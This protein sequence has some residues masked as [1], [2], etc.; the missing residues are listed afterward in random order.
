MYRVKYYTG[1]WVKC[2]RRLAPHKPHQNPN[3]LTNSSQIV[4]GPVSFCVSLIVHVRRWYE[5]S[6]RTVKARLV[7]EVYVLLDTLA[8]SRGDLGPSSS[9][10]ISKSKRERSKSR[11]RKLRDSDPFDSGGSDGESDDDKYDRYVCAHQ[12]LLLN[13]TG[14]PVPITARVHSTPLRPFHHIPSNAVICP[15]I[16]FKAT[17]GG[18]RAAG[19]GFKATG[20]GFKATWGGF[21]A[22]RVNSRPQGMDSGPRGAD[23]KLPG[24]G[25]YTC[26]AAACSTYGDGCVRKREL[27]PGAAVC[28]EW[29]GG[30]G[31]G[32]SQTAPDPP[33]G[34]HGA[35]TTLPTRPR[36]GHRNID[37]EDPNEPPYHSGI[38]FSRQC[39]AGVICLCQA[40]RR[41]LPCPRFSLLSLRLRARRAR[42]GCVVG[43]DAGGPQAPHRTRGTKTSRPARWLP[44]RRQDLYFPG[45]A[46]SVERAPHG[47]ATLGA[48]RGEE[49]L[50]VGLNAGMRRLQKI[51]RRA[52]FP[53]GGVA[54]QG[55]TVRVEPYR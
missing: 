28:Q 18:F 13:F 15:G 33:Q 2:F 55:L 47:L 5:H 23:P 10:V 32:V 12:I 44:R 19:G 30:E 39:F 20:G 52:E 27:R 42:R 43:A 37:R 51:G 26:R 17:R 6:Q 29:A 8:S 40:L 46:R 11:D 54:Q 25:W 35:H 50:V 9:T 45:V 24:V 38:H 4:A 49:R 21:K 36:R 16:E 7:S 34:A 14:P 53:S 22:T 31:E 48:R 41:R 3:S 1:L